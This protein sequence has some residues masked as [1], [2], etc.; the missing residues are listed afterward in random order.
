MMIDGNLTIYQALKEAYNQLSCDNTHTSPK[1][2]CEVL[3]CNALNC[4]RVDLALNRNRI[5]NV[6]ETKKF[7]SML[8]RRIAHEPISYITKN[9][10]FMSLDFYV[11]DG[12][13][14][15]RPETE[16]LVEYIIDSYKHADNINIIDLCT[17]SGAIAISLAYYLK[18]AHLTAVDMFDTCIK[19]A[20][21]NAEKHSCSSR[22]DFIKADILKNFNMQHKFDCI[23]SN[24]P[25]IKKDDLAFLPADVKDFEP[26]YA[27]DGGSD[28]LVFYREIVRFAIENLLPNGKLVLEIGFDQGESVKDI[29]E[30]SNK[31]HSIEIKKDFAGLDRMATAIK[32]DLQNEKRWIL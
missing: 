17:G 7:F 1:L 10:E 22:I 18:N 9:K 26:Q 20:S 29:I 28:G 8:K 27:L 6:E 32:G 16:I 23:V 12:V 2:D 24:P 11:E 15:P 13:L 30:T 4:S 19:V 3:L 21:R 14:I 31:F 25:Y 5:L